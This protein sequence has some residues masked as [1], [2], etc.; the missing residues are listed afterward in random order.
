MNRDRRVQE[1]ID[2]HIAQQTAK[3]IRAGMP[4]DEAE[5]DA[6]VR[7]GGRQGT[8]EAAKDAAMGTALRDF[9]RDLRIA[10]R[11]LTRTPSF[12]VTAILTFGLGLGA[13][14]AMFAVVKGVLLDPLPYPDSGRIVRLYQL[15]AGGAR[16]NVAHPN[17]E[18]WTQSTR[19][20]EHMT[21]LQVGGRLA[22]QGAG[23]PQLLPV[24]SV[25]REFFAAMRVRPERGRSFADNDQRV[26]AA[27]VALVSAALWARMGDPP[28]PSGERLI[29][30][31]RTVTVVGV[32]PTEFDYPGGTA[33][34]LP[35]DITQRN[36]S[37]T[38][39]NYQALARLRDDV[40][41]EAA[42]AEISALSRRL[43]TQHG[44]ATWMSDATAV[45][46]LEVAT[47]G[48]KPALQWLFLASVLLLLVAATN[49]SN[50]LVARS[51]SRRNEFAVQL[52][53]GATP[54]RMTRQLL[55]EITA[56][57]VTGTVLGLALA[58]V[59]VRVF[60][61][62]GPAAAP[63]LNAV[64][65]DVL[66]VGFALGAALAVAVVLALVATVGARVTT[67]SS[68]MADASRTSSSSRRQLLVREARY[69]HRNRPDG[70]AGRWRRT[71]RP[72]SG[73]RADD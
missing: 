7:F 19:S 39:H 67:V 49:L 33:I 29:V 58:A 38:A 63:R 43:K 71:A 4:P 35:L 50:L 46:L 37:R 59:A 25:S 55:A 68:S 64:S 1:E 16:G 54:G 73:R 69:R 42:Q 30:G 34:W 6:R 36:T 65:I 22:V 13:S 28:Q 21:E 3:N 60:A 62:I 61:A 32:M 20:F 47:G 66:T 45:P 48:I 72:Q 31:S 12:A 11:T 15:G 2:F 10:F 17:F 23:D 53:I 27:P 24:T 56:L 41:L 8:R 57:S 70:G 40:S 14:T 18:D 52:A 9:V 5:R 51:V 44:D 26:G